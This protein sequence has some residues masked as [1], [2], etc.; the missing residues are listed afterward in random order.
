[1]KRIF[2][3]IAFMLYYHGI[4]AQ[5]TFRAKVIN[6]QTKTIL[7]G[8]TAIIPDLKKTIAADTSGL[9]IIPDIPNGKFAIEISYV[10]FSKSEKVYSFP[11]QHPDQ[12]LEIGLEP[13][14]GELAEVTIQTT[15]TNQNLRDIPT[16]IEALPLEELDEKSTMRPGDIKMLLGETTGIHVQQTS[17]VS[18]SASFR[19]QGLDSRY[20]QL[21]QDG[22]PLYSGFSGNLSLLQISPL[23]LKQVEF[24][25]GS[26]STLYGGGAIAG[27]VNLI[28]K[29][30]EK[31]PELTLLL[32]GTSAKGA[33][34]SIYYS[35]KWQ[36]IGTTIFGSYNYNGAFDPSNTGFTAIPQTNRFAIN[37]KVFLY[38]DDHNSGWFG[39]NTTYENRYGG[40]LQVIDGKADNVHQYFERNKTF[41][42]S[43]QLSFTHKIDE[44]SR[45]NF[46]NTIGYFYRQLGEPE[47]NFK[48]KQLSSF[49]E[50]NY[51]RNGEKA[52]WVTGANLITDHFT[53]E[54]PQ[55]ALSYNLT[56]IGAFVQNTLKATNWFSLESGVRL[57]KNTPSPDKPSTGLF[58]LPRVNALFK[59]SDHLT[60]RIGGGLGY[61]MPSLFN[62]QSERDGYQNIKPLNIGNTQAE[63][64]Y[65]LNGDLN[66]RS[67]LGDEAVI[68]INQ[69][70]FSTRVDR[71]LILQNNTFINAPGHLLSQGAETNIKLVMDELVFYLGY[72]YTDT[73]QH[74]NGQSSTQPLTP[75]TQFSFDA[76][77]EI[78]GSFR[79]GAESFYTGPQLLSDGTTGK[80]YVTFGLLVQKMWKHLDIFVNAENLTAQ[81]QTKWGN[82]YTG[83]ITNPNFRDI[84]AP[85]DGVM[86]NA[87]IR[88]KLLNK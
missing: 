28:S 81:R 65:G 54:P 2:M 62:D 26:A 53:A 14:S 49:S 60:S 30:P 45:I 58:F 18:G 44:E 32:N 16:R 21:L 68:N 72:T 86:V 34:A 83:S 37:P 42:F 84:Y 57:D 17:A 9:I 55:N 76:T 6:D 35:Q 71:P 88:I 56:T 75:K 1:M 25:K 41:R 46:K 10:G 19:I 31:T 69:L 7:K 70:F 51:V 39:V 24:I 33:D 27:L 29:V 78:E 48:G 20:T 77:Y 73:K 11:L 23:N 15:R 63:Q 22:M 67:K 47:F 61:K 79:F 80:G 36:H 50:V 12:L 66:Y 4:M 52:S 8:A 74:F 85:L 5:N 64:S 87:G 82:I 40:D 13:S 43:T 38:M 3:F 59:L